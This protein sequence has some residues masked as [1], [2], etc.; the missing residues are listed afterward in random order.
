MSRFSLFFVCLAVLGCPVEAPPTEPPEDP[1]PGVDPTR[2]AGPG[3]VRAGVIPPGGSAA[4]PAGIASEGRPG[5]V[6]LYNGEVRFVIQAARR[7]NGYVDAGGNVIDAD[8]VRPDDQLGRDVIEDLFLA[9]GLGWLFHADSVEVIADGSDGPAVVRAVGRGVQWEFIN[10][11]GESD[12]PIVEDPRVLV[13]RD[14]RLAADSAVLEIETRFLNDTDELARF[15][16][17]DGWMAAREDLRTWA[18]GLGLNP[19]ELEEAAV[20]EVGRSL[21]GAFGV[22]RD[23]GP[24]DPLS[25]AGLLSGSGIIVFGAGW[26]DVEPGAEVLQRRFLGLGRD[27]NTLETIR[28]TQLGEPLGTVAGVVQGPDGAGIAGARVFFVQDEGELVVEGYAATGEDGRFEASLPPGAWDVVAVAR[29]E[30]ERVD[31]PP[32]AGRVG[33]Y[34]DAELEARVLAVLGGADA[35]A[36]PFAEGRSTPEPLRV[37][38]VEGAEVEV[39]IE[40][41][42]AGRLIIEV[43]DE[44]GAPLPAHLVVTWADDT[45]PRD[46]V[47]DAWLSPLGLPEG[48]AVA[49]VWLGDGRVELAVPP[50]TFDVS[51]EHSWRHERV[52]LSGL[53]VP[54]GGEVTGT[55]V[56]A[57]TVAP[58]GWMS[59]DS[60]LH[61]A[62]SGDGSL[63]MEHRVVA[64]AATGVELAITT[65]HDA[66]ADY[67]PLVPALGLQDRMA[68]LPGVEVSP[69]VRGHFNLF[70]VEPDREAQHGG[71]HPWWRTVVTTDALMQDIRDSALPASMIQ[72]NHGDDGMFDFASF[73]HDAG[74]PGNP[75]F[76]SWDFD[77][78]E[79]VNSSPSD[80]LRETWFSFLNHG[81]LKVP[82]GVSDS[83]SR[84]SACGRAHTD[85][86][87]DASDPGSVT[88][89]QLREA[90]MAG[91]VVV[92]AGLS[93]RVDLDGASPGDTVAEGGTI[94]VTL[95]APAHIVPTELRLIRNGEIVES[96]VLPLEST[97]GLWWDGSWD[98]APDADSWYVVEAVGAT[99]MGGVWGGARP[100]AAANA[101]LVDVG[102]DGWTAPQ[103]R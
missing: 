36:P 51:V 31:L 30:D 39:S 45:G 11:V 56:L 1:T 68:I 50:G 44:S 67:R 53:V 97:D 26:V 24:M 64:C 82:T 84:S 59:L 70:P 7:G 94:S 15:S 85:V 93:L 4:V 42:A 19:T 57:E 17:V 98:V 77:L 34:L 83:H 62:P 13:T 69:V 22:W 86:L 95:R 73:V 41:E 54:P 35:S 10:G 52:V 8:L 92:A 74:T 47:P 49:R 72:V 14:Y 75:D 27:L 9:F 37:D 28:R 90:L 46:A 88:G 89:E 87:L 96:V 43:E 60:H 33:P 63:P 81:Q 20:G 66:I 55:A 103:A 101:I 91:H 29:G 12:Q 32:H 48:G 25:I 79:L 80:Y 99:G 38:V 61:A 23:D 102:G 5:D 40:M 6:A 71:A 65:D 3:E 78:F 100:Y 18:T 76:F 21:E 58:D 2:P 16:A